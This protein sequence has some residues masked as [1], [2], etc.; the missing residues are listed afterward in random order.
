MTSNDSQEL[1]GYLLKKYKKASMNVQS[2]KTV[3]NAYKS[4]ADI[5][6]AAEAISNRRYQLLKA[7]EQLADIG[8]KT[9]TEATRKVR[10]FEI[11]NRVLKDENTRLQ[12]DLERLRL[13]YR[14]Q[15]G[16]IPKAMN[17]T[18]KGTQDDDSSG[19]EKNDIPVDSE[20]Q[21]RKPKKRGA[22][23]GHRG[24]TRVVPLKVDSHK[25]NH[26]P[27]QCDC[28]C[29]TII[30][31][32]QTDTKYIEDILPV[33]SHITEIK[34]PRGLCAKCG[35][36]V[37][38]KNA[39]H[40][41]PVSIGPNLSAHLVLLRQMG[42]TFRKLSHFC[43]ETL[44]IPLSPSGA[45]GVVSRSAEILRTTNEEIF[46]AVRKQ[47]VLNADETGWPVANKPAY[48]WGFCN[49]NLAYF[50]ADKSR[51]AKVPKA[52]L[53]DNFKGTVLCDFYASYNFLKKK[54]RCWIHL[55]RDIGNERKVLP[56]NA[57]LK[58]F[59]AR[60]WNLVNKGIEI[61][62]LEF[63]NQKTKGISWFAKELLKISRM[64]LPDGKASTLAKRMAKHDKDLARYVE[65][66]GVEYHNNR[67]ERQLRP[68]VI[69][70]KNSY[71]SNTSMGAERN[72]II[73]SVIETCRL[74]NIRPIDW[75]K[76]VLAA[77]HSIPPSPFR[78]K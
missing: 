52:I 8:Q 6:S 41:P 22:P 13:E 18:A 72:C 64:K 53:G 63:S 30:P 1:L 54:Q 61:S 31:T 11:E 58:K 55:L 45:L 24:N 75:L 67:A 50:H 43:T 39:R 57:S 78:E 77:P 69:A 5:S 33:C 49:T 74:N 20:D 27:S 76:Q 29:S 66:P 70:R 56:G 21:I 46:S 37:R 10:G 2:Q 19:N 73:N 25:E 62:K 34:Y 9:I 26:L 65:E 3:L 38:H 60:T 36:V 47:T 15:I 42:V 28:G 17:S 51:G 23:K 35:T 59:E 4:I 44:G 16:A 32:E 14:R 7:L 71:G 68:L 12:S 40:G 48:I